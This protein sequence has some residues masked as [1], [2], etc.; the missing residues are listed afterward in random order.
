MLKK[1]INFLSI[2][3][4][5][6]GIFST[7][8]LL[9]NKLFNFFGIQIY[10][11]ILSKF[12]LNL[13]SL[14]CENKKN[15]S[16][17][18]LLLQKNGY[19]L[20]N[21]FLDIENFQKLNFFFEGVIN[22]EIIDRYKS[23]YIVEM[24]KAAGSNFN[25]FNY[26]GFEK[27]NFISQIFKEYFNRNIKN[28]NSSIHLERIVRSNNDKNLPEDPQNYF[29]RDTFFGGLKGIFFMH[30][31]TEEH[32]TLEYLVGSHKI[33]YKKIKLEYLNSISSKYN[34]NLRN[35][36]DLEK[37][38]KKKNVFTCKKNTLL[39]FDVSGFH[40]RAKANIGLNRDTIRMSFRFN[41][42]SP[43]A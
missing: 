31:V 8:K 7:Q 12:F 25:D 41:P 5:Y 4:P 14:S 16:N 23:K 37:K 40:R 22:K 27:K 34:P 2:T 15:I 20:I 24:Y 33:D 19:L 26:P 11:L 36:N 1:I 6:I 43:F 35:V 39:L 17:E 38:Y 10:R 13:R 30:D 29:H 21:N 32:G 28:S 9:K 42:F 18:T 3:N